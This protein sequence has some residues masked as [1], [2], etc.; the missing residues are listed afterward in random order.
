MAKNAGLE[1]LYIKKEVDKAVLIE[2]LKPYFGIDRENKQICLLPDFSN[3]NYKGGI[4][5]VLLGMKALHIEKMRE[6]ETVGPTK[7][8]KISKINKSTVKNALRELEEEKIVISEKGKYMI[9]NF[10]IGSGFLGK[11]LE[12]LKKIGPRK[13]IS[14][15]KRKGPSVDI[16][17]IEQ[18]FKL[19]PEKFTGEF[20]VFI[21]E[22]PGK[23]L[24]KS[25]IVLKLAMDKCKI[26]GLTAG[27][28][29][30]ILQEHLRVPK[31]YH[32]NITTALGSKIASKYIFKQPTKSKKIYLYKLT[33]PGE[34]FVNGI[35]LQL[36]NK[37]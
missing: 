30:K 35:N 20:Y 16:S 1:D 28:I 11:K 12:D 29:T 33:K 17:K 21:T 4:I 36:K 27:E 37:E 10:V 22:K 7:I 2:L 14:E 9:P 34:D 6:T 23:Y 25:L 18:I 24:E 26:D 5:I 13:G 8:S 19:S 31:V 3:L 32:P 15:R